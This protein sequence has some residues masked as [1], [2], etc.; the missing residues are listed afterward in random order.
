[1][2]TRIALGAALFP[3]KALLHVFKFLVV[4]PESLTA[5]FPYF[6]SPFDSFSLFFQV[7]SEF[8]VVRSV[9]DAA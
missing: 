6:L 1:M 5:R 9:R 7:F 3:R 4:R 8:M 2:D